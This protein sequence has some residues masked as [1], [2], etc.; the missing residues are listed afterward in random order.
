MTWDR[1][2]NNSKGRLE[3]FLVLASGRGKLLT[4][5]LFFRASAVLQVRQVWLV[6]VADYGVHVRL[7]L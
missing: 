7:L 6:L 2:T 1:H 4:Q 5:T 3:T